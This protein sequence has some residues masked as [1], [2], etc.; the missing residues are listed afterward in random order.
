MK[1]TLTAALA[2][3]TFAGLALATSTI[4]T[5]QAGCVEVGVGNFVLNPFSSFSGTANPTLADFDGS[6]IAVGS[7][8]IRV[9]SDKGKELFSAAYLPSNHASASNGAGWYTVIT[10]GSSS[11]GECKNSYS[12]TRGQSIQFYGSGVT[13]SMA[14]NINTGDAVLTLSAGHNFIGN[15]SP[16]AKSLTSVSI[17]NFDPD[18][19]DYVFVNGAK[20]AYYGGKWYDFDAFRAAASVSS[21]TPVANNAVTINAGYGFRVYCRKRYGSEPLPVVTLSGSAN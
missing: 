15:V 14:G 7:G 17:A 9:I 5:Q 18:G 10:G 19:G 1:K 11:Y 2:L 3:S 6:S 16:V 12:L 20:Y 13:L 8:Y 21:L 4:N